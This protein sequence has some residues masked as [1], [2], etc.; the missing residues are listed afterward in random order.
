M[1]MV[2]NVKVLEHVLVVKL[3][4]TD[5]VLVIVSARNLVLLISMMKMETLS[6]MKVVINLQMDMT[7]LFTK[8][9]QLKHKLLRD[10]LMMTIKMNLRL[11]IN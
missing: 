2:G 1:L 3:K 7:M 11:M 9:H 6:G 10:L 5:F 8:K 4:K